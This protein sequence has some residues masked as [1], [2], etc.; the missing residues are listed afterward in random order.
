LTCPATQQRRSLCGATL[1]LRAPHRLAQRIIARPTTIG[2]AKGPPS[3]KRVGAL[4]GRPQRPVG[5][6]A[7][8]PKEDPGVEIRVAAA[9]ARGAPAIAAAVF[10]IGEAFTPGRLPTPPSPKSSPGLTV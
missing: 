3:A 4:L 6:E 2:A 7:S 10:A 8:T 9:G 1:V 5:D